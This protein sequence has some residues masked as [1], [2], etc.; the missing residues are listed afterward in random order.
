VCSVAGIPV[1]RILSLLMGMM[2]ALVAVVL[3]AAFLP[4]SVLF[5]PQLLVPQWM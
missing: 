2:I 5:L 4:Q 3:A 1:T